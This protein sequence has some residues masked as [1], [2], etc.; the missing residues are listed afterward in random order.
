MVQCGRIVG[1]VAGHRDHLAALLQGLDQLELVRRTRPGDHIERRNRFQRRRLVQRRKFDAG[2]HHRIG[3]ANLPRDLGGSA[4]RVPGHDLDLDSGPAA[5]FNRA[6]HL[7]AH[8]VGDRDESE[9]AQIGRLVRSRRAAAPGK[10]QSPAALVL[11]H[12]D[13]PQNFLF[14]LRSQRSSRT[15]AGRTFAQYHLRRALQMKDAVGEQ[16]RHELVFGI[17][18]PLP[19]QR[20]VPA[21]PAIIDAAAVA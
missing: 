16:R 5:G 9:P 17:E 4:G 3:Q 21:N 20:Q 6:R 13:R 10:P 12:P 18:A 19:F 7:G 15:V 1:A 2:C 8:R 11:L 14:G